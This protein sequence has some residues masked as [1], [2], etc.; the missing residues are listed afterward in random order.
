MTRVIVSTGTAANI[1]AVMRIMDSAFDPNFGEAW[2]RGQ[3]LGMMSLSDVWLILAT[4]DDDEMPEGFALARLTIDEAE[5]LL[6]AVRPEARGRGIGRI[7][8]EAVAEKARARGALRLMLE[9]REGNGALALYAA[10][11]FAQIGRR[12][13]YYRGRDMSRHDAITLARPLGIDPGLVA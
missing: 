13:D 1:E 7:L 11:G 2:N 8:V 9:M 3:V 4:P 10:A 6:L 5:L 12:R